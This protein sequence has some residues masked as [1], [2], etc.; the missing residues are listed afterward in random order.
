[1]F[2]KRLG[3]LGV[4]LTTLFAHLIFGQDS[5]QQLLVICFGSNG[6]VAMEAVEA[7]STQNSL[8][9]QHSADLQTTRH[10]AE[11]Q[12][13]HDV[14]LALDHGERMILPSTD[15]NWDQLRASAQ[16]QHFGAGIALVPP[17]EAISSPT[18][19]RQG[20]EH[21]FGKPPQAS[22][23]AQRETLTHTILLI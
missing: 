19:L 5:A 22:T 13:C 18:G 4:L 20:P 23:L 6:H 11:T 8:R 12:D 2:W 17:L 3:I 10:C 15:L 7:T 14:V 16:T 21:H 1:M 9:S